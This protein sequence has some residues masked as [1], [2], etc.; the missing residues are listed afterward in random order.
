MDPISAASIGLG[1][2]SLALQLFAGC[3]KSYQLYVDATDMPAALEHIRARL[4]LEQIRLLNWG[5]KAGLLEEELEQP[6]MILQLHRNLIIDILLEIQQLLKS[7]LRIETQYDSL[8][9][10]KDTS[11]SIAEDKS[12]H[13]LRGPDRLLARTLRVFEKTTQAPGRLK[14]AIVE[15]ENFETMV[16]K[17]ISYNDSIVSLLDRATI[18][19][20]HE[21]QVQ[22]KLAILQLS[23]G[24]DELKQLILAMQIKKEAPIKLASSQSMVDT[25]LRDEGD[26][27]D[28]S[29]S[30]AGLANF[31]AQQMFIEAEVIPRDS[32]AIDRGLI[33]TVGENAV[34]S[35]AIFDDEQVW[36]EW[37]SFDPSN[38]VLQGGQIIEDRVKKLVALLSLPDKPGEFRAPR[39]LGFFEDR[40]EDNARY[41]I[42][43]NRPENSPMTAQPMSLREAILTREKPSLTQRVLLAHKIAQSLMYLHSVNWLHKGFRSDNIIFFTCPERDADYTEPILSGFDFSRPDLLDE[44][45]EKPVSNFT[46]DMYRHPDALGDAGSR[47][48]KSWDIYS[49]GIVLVELAHWQIIE[50]IIDIREGQKHARTRMRRMRETMLENTRFLKTVAVNAG[51]RYGDVIRV[52]L[53]GGLAVGVRED[54]DESDPSTGADMLQ[55]FA[56]DVVDVLGSM[57]L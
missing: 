9:T 37:K 5:E 26:S 45:T 41:G 55:A 1:V 43:Y 18:D 14:W 24:I 25:L 39:C 15:R 51:E 23:G 3:V 33:S 22:S 4:R 6:S 56:T 2:T 48:K 50:E 13:R 57:R 31:K 17:L 38:H 30:V 54:E 8:V 27:G 21:V 49:L 53:T 10:A 19:K 7:C 20:L 44:I 42:V 28:S 40:D 11:L 34:R 36:V 35:T 16:S 29:A 52:C 47:S 46:H 32:R 12:R